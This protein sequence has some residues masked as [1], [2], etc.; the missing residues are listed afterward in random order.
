MPLR[1]DVEGREQFG[2]GRTE[3]RG[4]LGHVQDSHIPFPALDAADVVP[5]KPG[6]FGE[7]LLRETKTIAQLAHLPPKHDA[8]ILT[9][10]GP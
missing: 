8:E 2:D 4:Q 9:R 5:V 6:A 3:R 7:L 10:H 1:A